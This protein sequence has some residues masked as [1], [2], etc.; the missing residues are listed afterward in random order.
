MKILNTLL[1]I[2][3]ILMYIMYITGLFFL[4]NGRVDLAIYITVA[5][6]FLRLTTLNKLYNDTET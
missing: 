4:I 2:N 1:I 6:I 3:F 5:S